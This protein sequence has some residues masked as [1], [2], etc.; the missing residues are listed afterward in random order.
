[1]NGR[2][3]ILDMRARPYNLDSYLESLNNNMYLRCMAANSSRK[4]DE[5]KLFNSLDVV[6]ATNY[7]NK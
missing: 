1:M 3:K 5:G 7:Y 4:I 2:R 6:D